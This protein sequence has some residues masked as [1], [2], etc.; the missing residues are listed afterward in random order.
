MHTFLCIICIICGHRILCVKFVLHVSSV[1]IV[2]TDCTR[3]YRVCESSLVHMGTVLAVMKPK[4]SVHGI[5]SRY[6][7][8]L[9]YCTIASLS[10]HSFRCS[11]EVH[12]HQKES[13]VL[14][15]M[16]KL[17]HMRHTVIPCLFTMSALACIVTHGQKI[18]KMK[19]SLDFNAG[20]LF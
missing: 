18:V 5:R 8:K 20:R 7:S 3:C 16:V 9:Q 1:C 12:F 13:H 17:T 15:E 19:V 2:C 10:F 14:E 4:R 6:H 11:G